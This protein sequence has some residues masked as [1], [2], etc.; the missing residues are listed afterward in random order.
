M[1]D[2]AEQL[3]EALAGRYRATRVLGE[4]GMATVYVAEDLRHQRTVAIKVLR[5]E[6]VSMLGP[7]RFLTEIRVTAKLQHPHILPLFDSGEAEGLL[8]YVMPL[9]QGE[10]LR[11]RL[12]RERQLPVKAAIEIATAVASAL[13]HAHRQGV[14]HRDI[15]PE[16][17]LMQDGAPLVAD[18]G[19]ALA[20]SAVEGDRL[21]T[22]GLS[23]GSPYYMSPEQAAADQNPGPATDLYSLASVTYEM[24]TGEP[25]FPG[26]TAQSV[27]ARIMTSTPIRPSEHR[28]TVPAHVEAAVMKGLAKL[29]ADRFESAGNFAEA[30]SNPTVAD[31]LAATGG[32]SFDRRSPV[33]KSFAERW[34]RP[35]AVFVIAGTL[36]LAIGRGT[37]S[38]RD[39]E[40]RRWGVTFPSDAETLADPYRIGLFP[41]GSGMVYGVLSAEGKRGLYR[42][43]FT[44]LDG[45][46]I[47]GTEDAF[48]PTLSLD[49]RTVAFHREGGSGPSPWSVYT[50]SLDGGRPTH[51]TDSLDWGASW[52]PDGM[53]YGTYAP[54][55]GIGRVAPRGG[56]IEVL[57]TPGD[58]ELH[59]W[60]VPLPNG[61]GVLFTVHSTAGADP[62]VAV[63]SS[64]G[65]TIHLTDGYG[66]T[67]APTG[68][69]LFLRADGR[70]AVL[71]A[72]TFD[73]NRLATSGD[74][75]PVIGGLRL[76]EVDEASFWLS[77]DGMLTYIPGGDETPRRQLVWVDEA[78]DETALSDELR[79]Y[80]H[81]RISPDGE[82]VAVQVGPELAGP[83]DVWTY[84]I[85]SGVLSRV[86]FTGLNAYP[87]WTPDGRSLVY[88]SDR[89]DGS[90]RALYQRRADGSGQAAMILRGESPIWE[91]VWAPD[92]ATMILRDNG[93]Q[94]RSIYLAEPAQESTL[95][96][97]GRNEFDE[98]QPSLSPDGQ[99]IAYTSNESGPDEVYVRPFPGPG[100]NTPIS[101]D[102]GHSPAWSPTE[103][104][105]FYVSTA[106][107]SPALWAATVDFEP[108]FGV[109]GRS[110]LFD[111]S[112]Y[113]LSV[114]RRSYDIAPG[115]ERFLF[116]R[117]E[118]RTGN[119]RRRLVVVHHFLEELRERMKD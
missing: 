45:T 27:M 94:R 103:N 117:Q 33:K 20:M 7:E 60:P 14:I 41:D 43:S 106:D 61:R 79:D 82:T 111:L 50:V 80:R 88:S 49:G 110:V 78:G 11:T 2:P 70:E 5:P 59:R 107:G 3:N 84:R 1:S 69:L 105:L 92:G 46:P 96:A 38:P 73:P 104:T 119:L 77:P 93:P 32:R 81:P 47:P 67:F 112:Q 25:P 13:D 30:L 71:H 52:G 15:K 63:F 62:V 116:V 39:S 89:L 42:R 58:D 56:A 68:H 53:L 36:G 48:A 8:Y 55:G 90:P 102:G 31:A 4:G 57:T 40:V 37:S 64:E 9:I 87:N 54:T 21:T 23:L 51:V 101:T 86:T 85:A 10:S 24:L 83:S 91:G 72:T 98:R 99:W 6:L 35:A 22:T 118:D 66:G 29:P 16:N 95:R 115:G 114:S 109:R 18:F 65:E 34:G 97:F 28:V 17:I 76:G 100:G 108:S 75:I 74:P 26:N 19:I 12:D 44:S 113:P